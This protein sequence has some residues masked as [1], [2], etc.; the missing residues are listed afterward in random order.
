MISDLCDLKRLRR[1]NIPNVDLNITTEGGGGRSKNENRGR[2]GYK[3][4]PGSSK[5]IHAYLYSRV[6]DSVFNKGYS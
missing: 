6:L 4:V 5:Y 2:G 1:I 3:N